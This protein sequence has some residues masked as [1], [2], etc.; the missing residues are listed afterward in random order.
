MKRVSA[1]VFFTVL[2]RGLCQALGW[3]FGLFGYKRDGNFAKCVWG[4]FASSA[5]VIVAIMAGMLVWSL[6][7]TFYEKHYKEAHCYDPECSCSQHLSRNV[8]YHNQYDGKGYVFN[9]L[10]GEKTVKHIDWIVE[11]TGK[12]S[13]VCYSDGKKRG[14]FNKYSGQVVI[15]PKYNHAWIFSEGIACVDEDGSIKFIDSTGKV[16]IDKHMTYVPDMDGYL[17]HGGYCVVGSED[18]NYGLMDKKGLM[19][20]EPEY[21][22]IDLNEEYG[23][24]RVKKGEEMAVFDKDLNIVM[25]FMAPVSA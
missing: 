21:G 16:V 6:G 14:Y 8:Y 3:F 19:V 20:M 9:T 24:W 4:L 22:T 1:K 18:G 5:A 11:P 13:L 2:W 17:F 12:D 25:P 15:E 7:E 10:T 23:L